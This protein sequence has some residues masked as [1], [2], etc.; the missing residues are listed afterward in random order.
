MAIYIFQ[1]NVNILKFIYCGC[2]RRD[3]EFQEWEI[4]VDLGSGKERIDMWKWR[5]EEIRNTPRQN[6][7]IFRFLCSWLPVP[8]PLW[9]IQFPLAVCYHCLDE[10]GCTLLAH[11][12]PIRL[13]NH[14]S[15]SVSTLSSSIISLGRLISPPSTSGNWIWPSLSYLCIYSCE[16]NNKE[17]S[18]IS[19]L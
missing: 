11:P 5:P 7:L 17:R 15:I 6:D 3:Y 16:A 18:Q 12:P 4:E 8:V 14:P 19:F 2:L 13:G 1:T 9:S 10:R